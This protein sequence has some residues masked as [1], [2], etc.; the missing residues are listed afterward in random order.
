MQKWE[1]VPMTAAHDSR[2]RV[3]EILKVL[4]STSSF[5]GPFFVRRQQETLH[6]RQV[7][8]NTSENSLKK[9]ID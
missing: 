2:G 4:S 5:P 9:T 8:L 6:T 3:V 1:A 7:D